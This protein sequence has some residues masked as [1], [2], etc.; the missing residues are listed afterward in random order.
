MT[1]KRTGAGAGSRVVAP[2]A[3]PQDLVPAIGGSGRSVTSVM[4]KRNYLIEGLSG[5]GKSTVY[6]ELI[7]RGHTAISTDRTWAFFADP[8]HHDGWMW[9]REA[10]LRE[11]ERMEPDVLF[12]CGGCPNRD[13]F[14]PYFTKVFN[15]HV[16]EDTLRLRLGAR[17]TEDW[18]VGPNEIERVYE[19]HRRGDKP[20]EAIDIDST[21]AIDQVVDDLLRLAT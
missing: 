16:D 15:L 4:A 14:L 6:D 10:A 17:T 3:K 12:V 2:R 19:L 20:A 18:D 7:R 9:D 5:T 21:R 13:D 8:V 1:R 11:L